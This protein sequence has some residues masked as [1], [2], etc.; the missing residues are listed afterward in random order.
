ML[1]ERDDSFPSAL[2]SPGGDGYVSHYLTHRKCSKSL[3]RE[4]ML[5]SQLASECLG[6]IFIRYKSETMKDI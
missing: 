1:K 2:V 3:L 6:F 4:Y 5:S